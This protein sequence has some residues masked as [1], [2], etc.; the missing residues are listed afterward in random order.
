VAGSSEL[1]TGPYVNA[2]SALLDQRSPEWDLGATGDRRRHRVGDT[3]QVSELLEQEC[4]KVATVHD[5]VALIDREHDVR[6]HRE[7]EPVPHEG[8]EFRSV[9]H[10]RC[11]GALPILGRVRTYSPGGKPQCAVLHIEEDPLGGPFARRTDRVMVLPPVEESRYFGLDHAVAVDETHTPLA[12]H[13]GMKDAEEQPVLCWESE[14]VAPPPFA[15]ASHGAAIAVLKSGSHADGWVVGSCARFIT[16]GGGE[17]LLGVNDHDP[18]NNV[19][20]VH[21]DVEIT[22]PSIA[23]WRHPGESQSC[24]APPIG[25]A[26]GA[27]TRPP[28]P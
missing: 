7:Q 21:F 16:R 27:R 10:D 6:F 14:P 17:L 1:A 24:S 26:D 15:A 11:Q 9:S 19:G 8:N 25:R 12:R 4:S 22:V 5:D 28:S 3:E 20:H 13:R 18:R 2:P 23:E